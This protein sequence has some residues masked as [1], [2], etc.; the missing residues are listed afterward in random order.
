MKTLTEQKKMVLHHVLYEMEMYLASLCVIRD[1]QLIIN[2]VV[3]SEMIHLRNLLHFF[4]DLKKSTKDIIYTDILDGDKTLAIA[5]S[6]KQSAQQVAN[7]AVSLL[8]LDRANK[9]LTKE[10]FDQRLKMR[11]LLISRIT[12]FLDRLP[13]DCNSKYI[14]E[15]SDASNVQIIS[16]IRG[17]LRT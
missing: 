14:L 7:R 8:S 6:D 4:S 16:D 17:M 2:L 12:G 11:P 1:N 10:S 5:D 9:D 13:T 15:L 3:E